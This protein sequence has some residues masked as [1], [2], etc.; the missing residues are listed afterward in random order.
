MQVAI[1]L[2]ELKLKYKNLKHLKIF[3]PSKILILTKAYPTIA[4]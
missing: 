1:P 4:L 2:R 3:L